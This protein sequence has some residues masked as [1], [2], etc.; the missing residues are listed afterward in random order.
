V[1]LLSLNVGLPRLTSWQ[2]RAI[3]TAIFKEPVAGR[4]LLRQLNLDGDRQADLT[5]HGG[6]YKAVYGYPS[7][8]YPFWRQELP[9]MELSF[10][11][12]GENFTTEGL[13]ETDV[14]I[15]DR[16][17]IGS[18]IIQ[19]RQ[20][21]TPCYKLAGKFQRDDMPK[22]FLQSGR[23]GFYFSVDQEGD[24]GAGD[25]FELFSRDNAS[26]TVAE[27]NHLYGNPEADSELLRQAANLA[28]LPDGWRRYFQT[29]LEERTPAQPVR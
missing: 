6:P 4:V 10:G 22:R 23:S 17:H 25:E 18:A 14:K 19:V 7:E 28:A 20:P 27:I 12:F 29:K 5:V 3:H 13:L 1:K 26:L 8:H 16:Y 15:G 9:G 24:V 11:N 21:R 2:G